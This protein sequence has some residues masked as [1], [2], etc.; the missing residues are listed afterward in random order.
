MSYA[1]FSLEVGSARIFR[2]CVLSKKSRRTYTRE[3]PPAPLRSSNRLLQMSKSQS[4]SKTEA[5]TAPQK[6]KA[7]RSRPQRSAAREALSAMLSAAL[8]LP[9]FPLLLFYSPPYRLLRANKDDVMKSSGTSHMSA[10]LRCFEFAVSA[11]RWRNSLRAATAADRTSIYSYIILSSSQHKMNVRSLHTTSNAFGVFKFACTPQIRNKGA[12]QTR[13]AGAEE[14]EK[15]ALDNGVGRRTLGTLPDLPLEALVDVR[16]RELPRED[17]SPFCS[18][19]SGAARTSTTSLM[20]I[21]PAATASP[22][23]L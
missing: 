3:N 1:F 6:T 16:N 4:M 21:T 2:F 10:I 14:E 20:K 13:P 7:A 8:F 23:V 22:S 11:S 17:P 18:R 9:S 12:C 15:Q 19:S 5:K